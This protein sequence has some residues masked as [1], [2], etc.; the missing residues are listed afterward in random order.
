[1]RHMEPKRAKCEFVCQ[2]VCLFVCE[3]MVHRAAC[4]A[5]KDRKANWYKTG[6]N[7]IEYKSILFVPVTK[8]SKQRSENSM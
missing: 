8:G 1:M 6:N 2:F 3:F 7:E 4:A 5:K